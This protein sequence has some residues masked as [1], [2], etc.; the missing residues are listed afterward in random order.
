M[1]INTN[2]I[3]QGINSISNNPGNQ[4]KLGLGFYLP[5]GFKPK[6]EVGGGVSWWCAVIGGSGT[7]WSW[8]ATLSKGGWTAKRTATGSNSA[9][10]KQGSNAAPGP[11]T[12]EQRWRGKLGGHGQRSDGDGRSGGSRFSGEPKQG[13]RRAS[14]MQREGKENESFEFC[15]WFWFL[16][17]SWCRFLFIFIFL[18]FYFFFGNYALL[19]LLLLLLLS[20]LLLL[21]LRII[22][23]VEEFTIIWFEVTSSLQ[24]ATHKYVY[25]Y[26]HVHEMLNWNAAPNWRIWKLTWFN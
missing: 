3:V 22:L 25:I 24:P 14:G 18:F 4:T 9:H 10:Q 6:Q 12:N 13:G 23:A 8:L 26:I 1:G 5:I 2:Y 20:L 21:L 7:A 19:L 17:F 16:L 15:F 11:E